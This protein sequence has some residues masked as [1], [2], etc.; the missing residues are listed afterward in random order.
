[1]AVVGIRQDI[2]FQIFTE[3]VIS[4]SDGKIV[5]NLMQQDSAAIR[6]VMRLGWA[7]ANPVTELNAD[8]ATRFPFGILEPAG[9]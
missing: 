8:N 1:M 2:T 6:A 7:V 3:G 4:D 5:L 9:S